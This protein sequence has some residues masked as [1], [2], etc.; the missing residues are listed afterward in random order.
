M[1]ILH[2][3]N[4]ANRAEAASLSQQ[5]IAKRLDILTRANAAGLKLNGNHA[6]VMGVWLRRVLL[7]ND[8]GDA[9]RVDWDELQRG[10]EENRTDFFTPIISDA[11]VITII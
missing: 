10:I 9:L 2:A 11:G 4:A 3:G 6:E 8:K 5:D 7:V 1:G